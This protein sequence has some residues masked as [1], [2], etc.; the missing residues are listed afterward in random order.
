[1]RRA[2]AVADVNPVCEADDGDAS[3]SAAHGQQQ[4]PAGM[5]SYERARAYV[6]GKK[7]R[8]PK[9]YRRW[10]VSSERPAHFGG[11]TPTT[12]NALVLEE[13]ITKM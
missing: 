5:F 9:S 12:P 11:A 4:L 10:S 1:M 3:D 7:L 13:M 6:R 2:A 8:G